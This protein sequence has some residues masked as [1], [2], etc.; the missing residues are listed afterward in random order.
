MSTAKKSPKAGGKTATKTSAKTSAKAVVGAAAGKVPTHL[1]LYAYQVGFGDCFLLQ[2]VYGDRPADRRHVLVD[3]GTT[4]TPDADGAALMLRVAQ[5]IQDKCGGQLDAV[6]ATHRH[7]DHIS[8]FATRV[9]GKGSGD[10][11]HALKPRVVLQPWTED[12]ALAE[13]ATGPRA[14]RA[15][16]SRRAV[17]ALQGMNHMAEE[18]AKLATDRPKSLPMG[19]AARLDFLGRDNTKNIAAVENLERMGKAGTAV[20]AHFGVGDPFKAILPGVTTH[21]LGPPTVE[22][23][24]AI[25]KQ[26]STDDN[27]FWHFHARAAATANAVAGKGNGPFAGEYA[28]ARQGR[29]PR[30]SR[31][32]AK[33]VAGARGNQLLGIVTMLDNAMNNTSLILLLEV[34]GKR[35]LFPGDAQI[36]NWSYA[37]SQAGVVDMLADV[38]LYKVGHH[39]SLNATPKSLWKA[40]KK[41]GA[42]TKKDRMTSVLSTM[43]GKH[44]K[45]E[46]R[47]EVPR[48]SLVEALRHDTHFHSTQEL[49]G[50]ELCE[51]IRIDF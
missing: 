13:D 33:H 15:L 12:L 4:G 26:R 29:L 51:L 36:E 11:I 16:G 2:F 6:V 43:A 32:L 23:Y 10:V 41:R 44:G 3:F 9:D 14:L 38:D 34:G 50:G 22:Q 31:W 1:N 42:A 39:G 47:T 30:E 25:Q 49:P 37:L 21:V 5:D 8:G 46:K 19:L 27:E 48:R 7:A 17:S 28:F 24:P 35:L 18:V 40:F 45:E 20:Y